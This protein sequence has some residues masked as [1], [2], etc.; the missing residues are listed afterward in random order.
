MLSD[1]ER[2]VSFTSRRPLAIGQLTELASEAGRRATLKSGVFLR[3]CRYDRWSIRL[4]IGL[5]GTRSRI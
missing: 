5:L 1:R 3:I 4:G 2:G